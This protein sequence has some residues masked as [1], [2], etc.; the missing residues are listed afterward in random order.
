[1][2]L[3]RLSTFFGPKKSDMI[4]KT[5]L[6]KTE[7][8]RMAIDFTPI[9]NLLKDPAIT[10]IMINGYDKIFVEQKGLL[11]ESS[12][13]F[14]DNRALNDFVLAILKEDRKAQHPGPYYDGTLANGYRY[15]IVLP[16]M[17][18]FGACVT[19]RKFSEKK[20][21]LEDL[22]QMQSI[23]ERVAHFLSVCVKNRMNLVV[24]GGTGSGKTTFLQA[25]SN[26]INAEERIVTIEDVPELKL[27]QKN[28]VQLLSVKVGTPVSI[29][30][31]LINSLRMRPDRILVG[32]CRRDETYEMMQA[33]NTGHE[34]SMTTV[35]ANTSSDALIRL[36]NLLMMNNGL[37][38]PVKAL[39]IQM[40]TA[41]QLVIQ[42]RRAS[43]G[44]RVVSEI[45]ELTG[46][47]GDVITRGVIF[48][49]DKNGELKPTGYVPRVLKL[50]SAR[51]GKFQDL[52]FDPQ[53]TFKKSA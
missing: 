11:V 8:M 22:V 28:W 12:N 46:M 53:S 16:P 18:P 7:E 23:T 35:H 39:R 45:L 26:E 38:L 3:L 52:L 25:L 19:I 43:S 14:S 2:R 15:N 37:E 5:H 41:L 31:C 13:R 10:E 32:E 51:G 27:H 34:G 48:A 20:F 29:R 50:V 4:F 21:T 9:A 24:S 36:E 30:D 47:E 17:T 40:V 1:M 49:L 6:R 44:Q 33:M 42:L